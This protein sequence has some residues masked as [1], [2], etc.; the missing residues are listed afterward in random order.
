VT[1]DTPSG[2]TVS[3]ADAVWLRAVAEIV[4]VAV[5]VTGRVVAVNVAVVAPPAIVTEAG[6]VAADVLLETSATE[7]PPAGA[8]PLIVTV[9]VESPPPPIELGL[10]VSPLNVGGFTVRVALNDVLPI[11]AVITGDWTEGTPNVVTVAVALV[12]PAG[13]VTVVGTVAA[14]VILELRLTTLPPVGASPL[15]VT[16][17]VDEVPPIT[18]V[19]DRVIP[20][21]AAGVIVRFFEVGLPL[22]VAVIAATVLEA[23]PF[24]TMEKLTCVLPAV[25]VTVAGTT[26]AALLD[27]RLTT[28]PPAGAAT[29]MTTTFAVVVVPPIVV[30][31]LRF[32]VM[33]VGVLTVRTAVTDPLPVAVIV[34]VVS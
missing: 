7:T 28:D 30:V 21:S 33:S 12:W 19:G 4:V 20:V 5:V 9:P 15:R 17:A 26:A 11:D 27:E 22:N 2:T 23:T 10:S 31:G 16:V 8:G 18:E 13:T 25:T 3:T 14:E 32:K 29:G 24:V 6:T 34:E 1:L